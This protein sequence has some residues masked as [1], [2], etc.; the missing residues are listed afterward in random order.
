MKK[1]EEAPVVGIP[2]ALA[3]YKYAPFLV[4]FLQRCGFQVLVSPPT[5]SSVMKEG[6]AA[7]VEDICV[8][9]KVLFGQALHLKG[10]VDV[11]VVPRP[12]RV[13]KRPYDTFT[14]PKLM[15]APDMLRHG[16]KDV[17]PVEEFT[18]SGGH[19]PLW[20]GC[21]RLAR[22]LDVSL[23]RVHGAY[24][25]AARAQRRYHGYLRSGIHPAVAL[26][27]VAAGRIPED[28][29]LAAGEGDVS[30]AVIGH[31][32]LLGDGHVSH[33]LL[34]R[35]RCL[36][37]RVLTS[38]LYEGLESPCSPVSLPPLSWSYERELAESAALLSRRNDVD[39]IIYVTSFG[40]GPDSLMMEMLRRDGYVPRGVPFMELVLDEHD[41]PSGFH[42][43]IEAF[44]D[45]LRRR[46]TR[47]R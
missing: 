4:A 12:V 33:H 37:A 9:V 16:L 6:S 23:R 8:A 21:L 1:R 15:A 41:S 2:R 17:P 39:G 19:D 20:R 29:L 18:V 25:E 13:E 30:V 44:L 27:A 10:K 28:G 24:R 31:P 34:D 45:M 46:K 38:C 43:R 5:N 22:R 7:C 14:C 32:Y 47:S 35:L 26:E 36:G 11:M 42:S 40:C 3:A